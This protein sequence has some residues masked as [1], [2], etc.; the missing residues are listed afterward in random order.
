VDVMLAVT[1]VAAG[2]QE[3]AEVVEAEEISEEAVTVV[4]VEIQEEA[5]VVVAAA[6]IQE[7]AEEVARGVIVIWVN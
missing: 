6:G 7:E 1:V 3:E 4:V 2:I 5:E